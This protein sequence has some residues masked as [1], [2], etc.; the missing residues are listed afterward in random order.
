MGKAEKRARKKR[1]IKKKES[2]LKRAR[3]HIEKAETQKGNKDTTPEYWREEARRFEEQAGEVQDILDK[4][5][6]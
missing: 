4:I 5:E 2:L 6:E 1:L 3:E